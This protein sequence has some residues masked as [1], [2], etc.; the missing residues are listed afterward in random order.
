MAIA[1]P[2]ATATQLVLSTRGGSLGNAGIAKESA[3]IT[4]NTL[5]TTWS[6]CILLMNYRQWV[7][8]VTVTI[9]FTL[10]CEKLGFEFQISSFTGC[11]KLET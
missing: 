9:C 4:I 5:L 2:A 10:K 1:I 3:D 8:G 11:L 6:I 7:V